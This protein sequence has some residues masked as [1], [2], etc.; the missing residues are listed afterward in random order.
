MA[1]SS[2]ESTSDLYVRLG[3]SYDELE[4][5]FVNAE[6]T[7]R[8]NM[9][10]LSRENQ[11]IDLQAQVEILGLDEA[12]DATKI[13]EVRQK[14]LQRQIENQRDRVRLAAAELR[15]MTERTGENSDQ[16][17]KAALVHERERA[18]LA[19]LERQLRELN[20]TQSET[21]NNE[22][23][24]GGLEDLV[25]GVLDKLPPQLKLAAAGFVTLSAAIIGAGKASAEL[26]GKWQELQ[27]SSYNLN[28][29]VNDTENFLRHMKLTDTEIDDFA[30][31]VHGITDAW[32]KGKNFAV[33]SQAI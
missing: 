32:T 18:A 7:I 17:Q 19:K 25:D 10:R 22:G 15:N 21:A 13:L 3:L 2:G 14:S 16:T 11:I 31:Y 27:K 4:S 23:G 33:H 30:G 20:E 6:R 26:I 8:D 12:A 1:R 28:M 29:S 24:F 5:G 9:T